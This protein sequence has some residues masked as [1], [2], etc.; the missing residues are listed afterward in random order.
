MIKD[1]TST[2]FENPSFNH[3]LA[4]LFGSMQLILEYSLY[5]LGGLADLSGLGDLG[6][7]CDLVVR[8]VWMIWVVLVN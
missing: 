2:F 6:G 5:F 7:L 8:L 1:Q 3:L 4:R